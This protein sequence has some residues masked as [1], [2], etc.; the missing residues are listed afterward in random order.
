MK[1]DQSI[2]D[3]F[4]DG[5]INEYEDAIPIGI[6]AVLIENYYAKVELIEGLKG[7]EN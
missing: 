7:W 5:L 4:L 1:I 2:H 3:E 6:M